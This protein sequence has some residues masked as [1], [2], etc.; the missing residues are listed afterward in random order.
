MHGSQYRE[1]LNSISASLDFL[2]MA[3]MQKSFQKEP[4]TWRQMLRWAIN[5]HG[6]D[7]Y[8]EAV[9]SILNRNCLDVHN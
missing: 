7:R 2:L 5:T 9:L 6:E 1:L 3:T 4:F 8:K